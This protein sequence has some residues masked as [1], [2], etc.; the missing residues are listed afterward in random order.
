MTPPSFDDS[1][2]L[3]RLF[4]S[5]W[6]AAVLVLLVLAIQRSFGSLLTPGWRHALWWI[7]LGRLLLPVTPTSVWSLFN[8]LPVREVELSGSSLGPVRPVSAFSPV[9]P[10]GS[11]G[12]LNPIHAR[13]TPEKATPPIPSLLAIVWSLGAAGMFLRLA[14]QNARFSRRVRER[15]RPASSEHNALLNGCRTHMRVRRTIL[16]LQGDAVASP[17][18]YGVFRTRLLLPSKVADGCTSSQLRHIFLHELAH[19]RRHDLFVNGLSRILRAL[20][21]FNPVLAW[22]FRRIR[23]DREL[24]TDALALRITGEQESR[25]YGLTIVNML[26]GWTKTDPQPGT[27]GI[28]EDSTSLEHRIRAIAMFR[29]PSRWAPATALLLAL[30]AAISWTNA[31]PPVVPLV[32]PAATAT[33]ASP[34]GNG[35]QLILSRLESIRLQMN[36]LALEL[37]LLADALSRYPKDSPQ[38][39][40]AQSRTRTL[41]DRI[42]LG[43][44]VP[45]K[46]IARHT[47]LLLPDQRWI[48]NGEP[49]T[50]T[51]SHDR[52]RK[53]AEAGPYTPI[54]IRASTSVPAADVI[55]ALGF[56]KAAG[57]RNASVG[58][59][60]KE[61]P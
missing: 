20:H 48:L 7:V 16:L 59:E 31:Q 13:P 1:R 33:A 24:A 6:Q 52:L 25:A 58:S 19:V 28:L 53:L 21:W 49:I 61:S 40:D 41:N 17:A 37:S 4:E 2:L 51:A 23:A 55:D 45:R 54:I 35:R 38:V 8:L 57:F 44:G 39:L 50:P 34:S 36:H 3:D 29:R 18:L 15:M 22:A 14:L 5:S 26:E 43:I 47:L 56:A 30:L 9:G 27:V 10:I 42:F 12:P 11:I 60:A 32:P 46:P